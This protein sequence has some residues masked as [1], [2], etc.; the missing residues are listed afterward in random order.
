MMEDYLIL[1]YVSKIFYLV[2]EIPS[3]LQVT[4]FDFHEYIFWTKLR[5]DLK[6]KFYTK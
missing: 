4:G 5:F 3:T 2:V 1:S 6:I